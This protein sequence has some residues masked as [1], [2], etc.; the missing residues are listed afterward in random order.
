MAVVA[1]PTDELDAVFA[2][3]ANRHRREIVDALSLQPYS[4]SQLARMRD[5]SLPAIHKHIRLLQDAGVVRRRKVGRTTFL[6]LD[7]GS[8]RSLQGW[9][10]GHHAYWGTETETLENYETFLSSTPPSERA[11]Q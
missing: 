4:I 9:L 3:L 6:T 8:L 11:V 1:V 5:L 7:R 10:A 2:A